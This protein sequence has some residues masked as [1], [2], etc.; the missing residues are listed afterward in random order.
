MVRLL[1]S[2][3]GE[4]D[5]MNAQCIKSFEEISAEKIVRND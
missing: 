4:D 2:E 5:S 1:N 3:Q